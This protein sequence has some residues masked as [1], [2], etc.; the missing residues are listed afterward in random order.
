MPDETGNKKGKNKILKYV[1]IIIVLIVLASAAFVYFNDLHSPN[2]TASTVI[3]TD[4]IGRN[5]TI[6]LPVTRVVS[7]DPS[8]TQMMYAIG[9][10]NLVVAD[11]SYDWW[12]SNATTL[13]K[14]EMDNGTASVEQVVSFKPNLVLATTIQSPAII[15]QLQNLSIPVLV[16]EPQNISNIYRDMYI[17]GNVTGHQGG[18]VKEINY[19]K[20]YISNIHQK[21]EN[22]QKVS[23][24][25]MLWPDPIYTV[26]PGSFIND[27][28]NTANGFNIASNLSSPYPIIGNETIVS[29]N[30]Q[31]IIVDNGTGISNISYFR[32]NPIWQNIS[33]VKDSK[34]LFLNST[35]SNEM[36]EPG[37]LTIY[38][39]QIVAEFLY[40]QAL[41]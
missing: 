5:V 38:A 29:D 8:N 16:L 30:P 13:P 41:T 15:D 20:N 22:Y 6:K 19:M 33:A 7:M 24:L 4:D 18:A 40:P 34:V 32:S 14:V 17:L 11:T 25:Y 10:G 9:A 2:K 1:S 26:G 21:V 27:I 3:V 37:P 23:V 36:N 39:V 28:I 12:P 31:A 35:E